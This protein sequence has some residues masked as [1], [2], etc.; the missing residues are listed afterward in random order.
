MHAA[1]DALCT[2]VECVCSVPADLRCY[3][4]LV[5]WKALQRPAQYLGMHAGHSSAAPCMQRLRK[6]R[7][8]ASAVSELPHLF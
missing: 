5:P 1:R 2:E 3:N 7:V 6:H 4:D 8:K